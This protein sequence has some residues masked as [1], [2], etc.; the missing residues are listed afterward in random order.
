MEDYLRKSQALEVYWHR[1]ITGEQLQAEMER[2]VRQTKQP[3]VLE[4]LGA[5]SGNDPYVIAECLARPVLANRLTRNRY[6]YSYILHVSIR[7][8]PWVPLYAVCCIP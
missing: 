3:E 2:M 7:A 6:A 4:E 1:P 5:A 8:L